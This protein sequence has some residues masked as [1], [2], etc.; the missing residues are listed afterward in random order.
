MSCLHLVAE[1]T[2]DEAMYESLQRKRD[3]IDSIRDG[4]FDF[5]YMKR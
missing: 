5:G 1:D 2:V 4:S 3:V